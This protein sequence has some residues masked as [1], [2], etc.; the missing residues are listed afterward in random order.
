[1]SYAQAAGNGNCQVQQKKYFNE[2]M[3]TC[4]SQSVALDKL[5]DVLH[6]KKILS[7]LTAIQKVKYGVMYALASENRKILEDLVVRG[8][9]VDG[10][11]L[12]FKYHKM[13]LI[14]VYVSNIPYGISQFDINTAFC[15]FGMIKVSRKLKKNFRGVELFTGD[16]IVSFDRLLIPIPSYVM[17]RGWLSYVHYDGQKPTCR[18]CDQSGHVFAN[19]P[20]R[21]QKESKP[22]DIPRNRNDERAEEPEDMDTHEPSPPNEPDLTEEEM[23]STPTMQE[24]NSDL[25]KPPQDDP[26]YLDAYQEILENLGS[27]V[28]DELSHVTVEECQVSTSADFEDQ[29]SGES[30]NNQSQAWADSKEEYSVSGTVGSEKP[31]ETSN[32]E[33][34]KTKAKLR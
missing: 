7:Q 32:T 33:E 6:D 28:T 30:S 4:E 17:V 24:E 16:W 15:K 31:Q 34:V 26:G 19:C 14:N 18:R 29:Q 25:Y 13:N 11:H 10:V 3:V 12:E 21:R 2:K 8:L 1:M 20:Q 9:E 23:K 22:E 5:V 27:T